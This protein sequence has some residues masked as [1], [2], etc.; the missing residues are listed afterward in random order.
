MAFLGNLGCLSGLKVLGLLKCTVVLTF[1]TLVPWVP[2]TTF[3]CT[4]SAFLRC[5]A[6]G[7]AFLP[8]LASSDLPSA[9]FFSAAA[10]FGTGF[11]AAALGSALERGSKA[12]GCERPH[13]IHVQSRLAS[14]LADLS[15]VES[16][17]GCYSTLKIARK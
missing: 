15:V 6:V 17:Q 7:A 13:I 10:F 11:L 2:F 4:F 8:D 12:K 16:L 9:D 14:F 5:R 3:F 1:F